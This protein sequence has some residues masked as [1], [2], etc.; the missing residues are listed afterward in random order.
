MSTRHYCLD[1]GDERDWLL[2]E[3]LRQWAAD[4][5][6]ESWLHT[7]LD[8]ELLP[9]EVEEGRCASLELQRGGVLLA[10]EATVAG[11]ES[12]RVPYVAHGSA[13]RR[14]LAARAPLARLPH[15]GALELDYVV[16]RPRGGDWITSCLRSHTAGASATAATAATSRRVT[17]SDEASAGGIAISEAVSEAAAPPPRLDLAREEDEQLVAHLLE[18]GVDRTAVRRRMLKQM[19]QAIKGKHRGKP[20]RPRHH[21]LNGNATADGHMSHVSDKSQVPGPGAYD[22]PSE[23]DDPSTLHH[24][25]Q[26]WF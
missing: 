19:Q 23:F 16:L 18:L 20:P 6:G 4:H 22:Q 7:A 3:R 21:R 1:L 26:S 5:V 2:A 15:H 25:G 14:P 13:M 11:H 8:G 12:E 17:I 24:T 10:T 9:S